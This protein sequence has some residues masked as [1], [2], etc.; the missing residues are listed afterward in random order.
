MLTEAAELQA[1]MLKQFGN[2]ALG[3]IATLAAIGLCA[4]AVPKANRR[5]VVRQPLLFLAIHIGIVL[6]SVPIHDTTTLARVLDVSALLFLL[7]ALS[8]ALFVLVV[9]VV[10]GRRLSRP[11]S[12]IF[13][14]IIQGIVYVGVG[15]IVLQQ[16]GVEPSSLLTTSALLT[17]VIGLSLQETLGNLFAGLAIQAQR[18]FE[19]GDWIGVDGDS[20][21][22]GR[23]IEINWRATTVL[24]NDQVELIIPNGVLAKATLSNYTKPTKMVRRTVEVDAPYEVSPARVEEALQIAVKDVPGVLTTPVPV[25]LMRNF[26]A[27]GITYQLQ[28]WI[29]DFGIRDRLDSAVRQR[30]WSAFQRAGIS[31]PFPIRTVHMYSHTQSDQAE[32]RKQQIMLRKS[33]LEGVDFVAALSEESRLELATRSR[34]CHFMPGE[35]V[36]RQGDLGSEFYVVQ[37]G[38]VAVILGLGE[39]NVAEV[40]RLGPGKFFGEMSLM[41][42]ASRT[43]TVQALSDT[44]LVE[45]SKEA[46]H[47]LLVKDPNLAEAVTNVLVQRQSEIEEN[48]SQLTSADDDDANLKS[49][50]LLSKIRNFFAL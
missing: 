16:V 5:T 24:T 21:N 10:L 46:F 37:K 27:S 4:L 8:R 41:T 32:E 9:D 25:V 26:A 47:A 11:L 3:I 20:T 13:R 43:A 31:I 40:A 15:A 6:V 39:G 14:D 38:E 36:L 45:V 34:T 18:P 28:F 17:A 22:L 35:I 30:I 50:A 2:S 7:L 33:S 19:I 12:R 42:G 49:I 44:E 29:D 23:V 1:R 48:L